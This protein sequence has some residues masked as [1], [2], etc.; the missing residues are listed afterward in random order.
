M[1]S[2]G[3]FMPGFWVEVTNRILFNFNVINWWHIPRS[4]AIRARDAALQLHPLAKFF[5]AKFEAKFGQF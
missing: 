4:S 2:L 5:L 3:D 1:L